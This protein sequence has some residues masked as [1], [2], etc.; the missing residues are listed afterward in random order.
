VVLSGDE[1][2]H[3][4][5]EV[6]AVSLVF[7]SYSLDAEVRQDEGVIWAQG[8]FGYVVRSVVCE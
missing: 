8:S 3:V 1:V 4:S 7:V 2:K 5:D 6:G